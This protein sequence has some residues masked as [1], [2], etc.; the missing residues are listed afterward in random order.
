MSFAGQ[1]ESRDQVLRA[2]L[3]HVA[4]L[5]WTQAALQAGLQDA[6]LPLALA[7][8]L[9]PRGTA[10][11]A[12]AFAAMADAGMLERVGPL[13][14][15]RTP[16][17]IRALVLA[18][19][20]W[21][22]AW[23]EPERRAVG[24]LALPWNAGVAARVLARTADAMWLAAGDDSAGFSRY[25]KRATLAAVQAA[26]LAFWLREPAP[27]REEVAAFLDRRLAGVARLGRRRAGG[28]VQA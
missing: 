26:T 6:G 11:M 20:E 1:E 28:G 3:P 4:R 14:G 17:R 8:G 18:R 13:D 21:L 10:G 12:E 5:G 7:G 22:D 19:L 25:S 23:R 2:V 24:L 15:L 27:A 16:G 9:F